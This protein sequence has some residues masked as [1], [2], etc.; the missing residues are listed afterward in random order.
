MEDPP[1]SSLG[2]EPP[3]LDA[4][5]AISESQFKDSLVDAAQQQAVSVSDLFA[6]S[7]ADVDL[8][9]APSPTKNPTINE[10]SSFFE[11]I[12]ADS[13]V[14]AFGQAAVNSTPS[15]ILAHS[16]SVNL[17]QMA[18]QPTSSPIYALPDNPAVSSSYYDQSFVHEQLHY[19]SYQEPVTR[20]SHAVKATP[21]AFSEHAFQGYPYY[22]KPV[23]YTYMAP[24]SSSYAYD[25]PQDFEIKSRK[26]LV[27][28][29]A[30]TF[31]TTYDAP[32]T[33]YLPT[34]KSSKTAV[35]SMSSTSYAYDMPEGV[36]FSATKKKKTPARPQTFMHYSALEADQQVPGIYGYSAEQMNASSMASPTT[37]M[38]YQAMSNNVQSQEQIPKVY[39][40]YDVDAS[41][42]RFSAVNLPYSA[43]GSFVAIHCCVSASVVSNDKN[44]SVGRVTK[45]REKSG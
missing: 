41:S 15:S 21:Q 24:H 29:V 7:S 1:P 36:D 28:A 18:N 43:V 22:E 3:V 44:V 16:S 35:Q 38:S 9:S 39:T 30:P 2:E 5:S 17:N 13:T 14:S 27:P 37:T 33:T 40:S 8:F 42:T 25:A 19:G 45:L 32:Q 26:S 11:T 20:N 34:S 10:A 4:A 6:S 23:E 31:A 12:N